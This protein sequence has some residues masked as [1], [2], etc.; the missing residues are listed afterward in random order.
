MSPCVCL[1]KGSRGNIPSL[2]A[3]EAGAIAAF[4]TSFT[5]ETTAVASIIAKAAETIIIAG[6]IAEATA[7]FGII[8]CSGLATATP[9]TAVCPR[10]DEAEECLA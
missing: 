1:G 4:T 6:I 10:H 9:S 3:V 8:E 5:T 2:A 7:G